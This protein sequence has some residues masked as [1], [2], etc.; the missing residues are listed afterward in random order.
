MRGGGNP[1]PAS[2]LKFPIRRHAVWVRPDSLQDQAIC[3]VSHAIQRGRPVLFRPAELQIAHIAVIPCTVKMTPHISDKQ[4]APDA[5]RQNE[6]RLL[7]ALFPFDVHGNRIRAAVLQ[8]GRGYY[9]GIAIHTRDADGM[10][11]SVTTRERAYCFFPNKRPVTAF[12]ENIFTVFG[13]KMCIRD[14]GTAPGE[15]RRHGH[16]RRRCK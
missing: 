3:G 16:N 6:L 7:P 13:K 5:A 15:R 12:Q 9:H 11:K 1:P 10:I 4:I 2:A 8:I 14:R